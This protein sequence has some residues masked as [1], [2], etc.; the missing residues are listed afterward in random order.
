MGD[1]LG[2]DY[3]VDRCCYLRRYMLLSAV[4]NVRTSFSVFTC[5][6]CMIRYHQPLEINMRS[7]SM[8]IHSQTPLS[9]MTL[10]GYC[11]LCQP[12]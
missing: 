5:P 3:M 4:R 11:Q 10:R 1:R 2:L 12:S 7:N 9:T 8:R 6:I